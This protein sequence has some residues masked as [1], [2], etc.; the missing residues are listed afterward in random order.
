M[1]QQ[2]GQAQAENFLSRLS[3]CKIYLVHFPLET[4]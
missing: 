1:D 4:N 3:I 2:D